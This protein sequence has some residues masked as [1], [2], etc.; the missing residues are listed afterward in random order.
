MEGLCERVLKEVVKSCQPL[1]TRTLNNVFVCETGD[2]RCVI[3]RSAKE[4]QHVFWGDSKDK[5]LSEAA[6]MKLARKF[7]PDLHVP[8]VLDLGVDELSNRPFLVM[9]RVEGVSLR[10]AMREG[11]IDCEVV[12]RDLMKLISSIC[13][14]PIEARRIQSFNCGLCFDGP[15][16]GPC[17]TM[18]EFVRRVMRWSSQNCENELV[19]KM[20]I[21]CEDR[22]VQGVSEREARLVFR[23]GDLSIDNVMVLKDSNK[24]C[25]I[26]W[27][28]AGVYDER[29]VWLEA[30]EMICFSCFFFC[31][32][33]KMFQGELLKAL[34]MEHVW[35]ELVPIPLD[36]LA[37]FDELKDVFMGM[38]WAA[39]APTE[40]DKQD[41]LEFLKESIERI[42]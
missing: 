37:R 14:V 25:F 26:D 23:H 5:Y 20:L 41:E 21:E 42:Q 7:L 12:A 38:S 13:N 32:Q 22:V 29:D 24:L 31:F 35:R 34:K 16:V 4:D 2:G 6:S 36:D 30:S 8:L 28:F 10:Q 17:D 18:A 40:E 3:V 11:S 39:V 33:L 9:E 1:S 27:E 15:N 19:R